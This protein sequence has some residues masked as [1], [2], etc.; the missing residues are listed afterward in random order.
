MNESD[1]TGTGPQGDIDALISELPELYQPIFGYPGHS[2]SRP[3]DLDRTDAVVAAVTQIAI[4]V[5]HPLRILDLGSAQGYFSFIMAQ[6][7]HSVVGVD[8]LPANVRLATAI[9]DLQPDLDVC[10]VEDQVEHFV[11]T[12]EPGQFDVVLG[13]S[14]LHHIVH[15]AGSEAA[16]ALVE[17]LAS[18]V[19]FGLFEMATRDEP[20]Y[21]AASQP[22]DP[23]VTLSPYAFI[24]AIAHSPTH[25]SDVPRPVFFCAAHHALINDELYDLA[26]FAESS[27][28]SGRDA[29]VGKRRYYAT[30]SSIVK[31]TAR[32]AEGIADDDL[33]DMRAEIRR[34]AAILD[35]GQLPIDTPEIRELTATEDEILIARTAMPGVLLADIIGRH[36]LDRSEIYAQLLDALAAL[37]SAGLYHNDLRTWNVLWDEAAR[38]LRL[39]DFGQ[40]LDHPGDV[41]WPFD[42]RYSLVLF[43]EALFGASEDPTGLEI[44]RLPVADLGEMPLRVVEHLRHL[45]ADDGTPGFFERARV[46]FLD[47]VDVPKSDSV[48]GEI[49]ARQIARRAVDDL[50]QIVPERAASAHNATMAIMLSSE[51]DSARAQ[52]AST[53]ERLGA[54]L[55][56]RDGQLEARAVEVAEQ[57][58]AIDDLVTG[59][60]RLSSSVDDLTHQIALLEHDLT[61]ARALVSDLEASVDNARLRLVDEQQRSAHLDDALAR[62]QS[63]VS[64]RV[65]GPI[66]AVRS[67]LPTSAQRSK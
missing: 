24:R 13:L 23:R 59:S 16:T 20:V 26:S 38:R 14:I 32:F 46:Q 54:E 1:A 7:G 30:A 57:Q 15:S 2:A 10:F 18:N 60:G 3:A 58:R 19:P 61:G 41:S 8:Y 40:L 50:T 63:S 44:P 22:I 51:L 9:A 53:E 21:W 37:E 52:L 33:A 43:A 42:A 25:L 17:V 48:L 31:I 35:A 28:A 56:D 49:W 39:I 64:W 67:L 55:A 34:E 5:G 36:D 27:H 29:I 45:C 65:T 12:V 62:L 4:A 11:A 6:A 47:T 66:R